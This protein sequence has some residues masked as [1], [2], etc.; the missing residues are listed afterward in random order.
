M[1]FIFEVKSG[2]RHVTQFDFDLDLE[3]S[4][5]EE[6]LA[7]EQWFNSKT[8]VRVHIHEDMREKEAK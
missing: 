1:K 7:I 4:S 6:L 2:M 5:P 8:N 3:I